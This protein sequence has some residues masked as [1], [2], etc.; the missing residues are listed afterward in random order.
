MSACALKF[1]FSESAGYIS[2][3]ERKGFFSVL[4]DKKIRFEVNNSYTV[5][6]SE[7]S[8]GVEHSEKGTGFQQSPAFER[9]PFVITA[10]IT[11]A[12]TIAFDNSYKLIV[13][14]ETYR[15][16]KVVLGKKDKDIYS[17]LVDVEN[18]SDGQGPISVGDN[19]C[20]LFVFDFNAPP[21][22]QVFNLLLVMVEGGVKHSLDVVFSNRQSKS[23][24]TH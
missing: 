10:F 18:K 16:S 21:P 3:W 1:V 24:S 17:C 14:N 5:K 6:A 13:N 20:I 2:G 23:I 12:S 4:N 8:L 19:Q 15:P 9:R 22:E 11:T 7:V